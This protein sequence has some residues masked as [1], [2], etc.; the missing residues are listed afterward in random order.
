MAKAKNLPATAKN[1]LPV[2]WE[3]Q[4]AAA[5]EMYKQMEAATGGGQFISYKGGTM[6]F[7]GA[8]MKENTIVAVPVEAIFEN[9]FY[10]HEFDPDD[11]H[12]PVCF[13]FSDSTSTLKPG[14][15]ASVLPL[16]MKPHPDSS[17]P[18]SPDCKSCRHAQFGSADKGRGK[19]CKNIRKIGWLHSDYLKKPEAIASAPLAISKV[20]ATSLTAWAAYVKKVS[21]VLGK[22]F[23]AVVCKHVQV[24][25]S[26]QP[27]WKLTFEPSS[28]IPKALLGPVFARHLQAYAELAVPYQAEASGGKAKKPFKG[29]GNAA[30]KPA[31]G[32]RKKY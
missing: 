23:Y 32:K 10:V 7:D 28:E 1:T 4:M 21:N 24:P 13:A 31:A 8:P 15:D 27:G 16:R 9:A 12:P 26:G 5:A 20:P 3:K 14:E 25:A 30:T 22:A 19:A 11:P 6:S 17:D 2:D 29:K 18:Q